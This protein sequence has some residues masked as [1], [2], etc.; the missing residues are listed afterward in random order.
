[1]QGYREPGL[2]R[3]VFFDD[4]RP[5]FRPLFAQNGKSVLLRFARRDSCAGQNQL[6]VR[7]LNCD[8]LRKHGDSVMVLVFLLFL[9]PRRGLLTE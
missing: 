7:F 9:L 3:T 8:P 6:P 2:S 4:D 1:M 5:V